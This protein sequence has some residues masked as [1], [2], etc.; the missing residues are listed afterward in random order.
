MSLVKGWPWNSLHSLI[1]H[2]SHFIKLLSSE[3]HKCWNRFCQCF[4]IFFFPFEG[5]IF[6]IFFFLCWGLPRSHESRTWKLSTRP[7]LHKQA[8]PTSNGWQSCP[9]FLLFSLP[10]ANTANGR[11]LSPPPTPSSPPANRSMLAT[12]AKG[13][14]NCDST[15]HSTA[16][17]QGAVINLEIRT[18]FKIMIVVTLLKIEEWRDKIKKKI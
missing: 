2:S 12:A 9:T 10:I 14:L 18:V 6:N 8:V 17:Y 4:F 7:P 5:N 11:R 13:S 15:W 1:S 16:S 3:P